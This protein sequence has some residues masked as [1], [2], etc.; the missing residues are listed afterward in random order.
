M[1]ALYSI[2][3]A[4]FTLTTPV[5][6]SRGSVG[7]E[8]EEE[9][10]RGRGRRQ[11]SPHDAAKLEPLGLTHTVYAGGDRYQCLLDR[12]ATRGGTL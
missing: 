11:G 2:C 1:L 7:G 9:E 5:S 6:T 8:E 10:G 12:P 3:D 4:R